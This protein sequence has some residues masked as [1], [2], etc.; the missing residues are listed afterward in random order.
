MGDARRVQVTLDARAYA[1]VSRIA[2]REGKKLAAVVREA[3]EQYCVLPEAR[4]RRLEA[5]DRLYATRA[6]PA[7]ESLPEWERQYS[8]LKVGLATDCLH[9]TEGPGSD[10]DS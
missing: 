9:T 4:Q 6:V 3:V 7:P 8:R 2:R 10:E 1:A 5:I